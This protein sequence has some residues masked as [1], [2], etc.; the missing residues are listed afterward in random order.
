MWKELRVYVVI[1]ASALFCVVLFLALKLA[2]SVR[3][4][5]EAERSRTERMTVIRRPNLRMP[6]SQDTYKT[7]HNIAP[8]ATVTVS[9]VEESDERLGGGVA[10]GIVDTKEWVTREESTGAWIR[11]SWDRPATVTEL[12][13]YDRP[14]RFDNVLSG[15]LS[16]D[17]GIVIS[18]PA[19]PPGG[20]PWRI[21]FPPKVVHWLTFQIDR[22]E[23][24]N[25]GLEEIMVFGTLNP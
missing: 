20:T 7:M 1:A 24:K 4:L 2:S 16:F 12:A 19:L 11:L 14:N 17:D 23:G 3:M 22:A 15:R 9:S 25:T 13:L 5:H 21:T 8:L 10:D 6:E 18:V